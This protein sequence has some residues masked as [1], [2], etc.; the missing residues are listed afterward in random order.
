ERPG[1]QGPYS[2]AGLP[3]CVSPPQRCVQP[4]SLSG[5]RIRLPACGPPAPVGRMQRPFGPDTPQFLAAEPALGLSKESGG[6]LR[7][8]QRRRAGLPPA[9]V[10]GGPAFHQPSALKEWS[11]GP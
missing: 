10:D 9:D 1:A 2:S 5:R 4:L 11:G 3:P 6:L 7:I 8:G